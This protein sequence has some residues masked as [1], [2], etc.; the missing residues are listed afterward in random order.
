MLCYNNTLWKSGGISTFDHSR[1]NDMFGCRFQNNI[2]AQ[3]L[4]LPPHVVVEPNLIDPNPGLTNPEQGNFELTPDSK[5]RGA[6]VPLAGIT[7][8]AGGEVPDLG[9]CPSGMPAWKAGHDFKNP[10]EVNVDVPEA[11]YGN[12]IRNA[13][14]ELGSTECWTVSGEGM[15]QPSKGNGWGNGFGR[16]AVEKTGTS[17]H[18]LKL[19]GKVRIEQVI[20]GLKPNT[21]YQL[22]GWFKVTDDK[23]PVTFG[24]SGYGGADA[25]VSGA[26][27]DWERRTVDFTTGAG[28]TKVTVF[29][30]RTADG[31]DAFVDNLG[32]PR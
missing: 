17:N 8:A 18:E 21:K 27:K 13:A 22:S 25:T 20:E 28:V 15:A 30:T 31:G 26:D 3:G 2:T 32:L 1:R 23:S 10:P 6:G 4:N 5:A 16:G 19:T 11:A 14:F 7:T 12:A 9:A 29:I 24:V